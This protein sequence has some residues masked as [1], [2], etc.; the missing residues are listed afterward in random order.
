MRSVIGV[1]N[2]AVEDEPEV[3][4]VDGEPAETFSDARDGKQRGREEHQVEGGKDAENTARVELAKR[5]RPVV[6]PGAQQDAHDQE[7][8]QDKEQPDPEICKGGDR[9]SCRRIVG[10]EHRKHSE[11]PQ[12]VQLYEVSARCWQQPATHR[13]TF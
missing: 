8:A 9:P 11:G 5:P 2:A 4:E 3:P 13:V 10:D 1:R 6:R 7:P 12:G